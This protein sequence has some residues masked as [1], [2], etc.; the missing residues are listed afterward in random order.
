MSERNENNQ[1]VCKGCVN[2]GE[3]CKSVLDCKSPKP[4]RLNHYLYRKEK[5]VHTKKIKITNDNLKTKKSK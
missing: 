3:S 2:R 4:R 1:M 5:Q